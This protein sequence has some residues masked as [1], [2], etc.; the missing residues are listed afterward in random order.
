MEVSR[1]ALQVVPLKLRQVNP[2]GKPTRTGR[3]RPRAKL[4][5][6]SELLQRPPP[7]ELIAC[8]SRWHALHFNG[9][10]ALGLVAV[11]HCTVEQ[12]QYLHDLFL[13]N[14]ILFSVDLLKAACLNCEPLLDYLFL[15]PQQSETIAYTDALLSEYLMLSHTCVP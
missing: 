15:W 6:G 1:Q 12:P 7:H 4:T 8:V 3:L 2:V 11:S 5:A 14:D 9:C 10:D 13:Y